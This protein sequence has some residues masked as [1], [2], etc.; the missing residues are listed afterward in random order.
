MP[1]S[2][3]SSDA[4]TTDSRVAGLRGITTLGD[5]CIH[6]ALQ[7]N[8]NSMSNYHVVELAIMLC[9][10]QDFMDNIPYGE[11][12]LQVKSLHSGPSY[13]T[14]GED[15]AVGWGSNQKGW[16]LYRQNWFHSH[17]PHKY[18]PLHGRQNV[19]SQNFLHRLTATVWERGPKTEYRNGF[20]ECVLTH[21]TENRNVRCSIWVYVNITTQC[22]LLK[23]V[24]SC[25][26]SWPFP[27][28]TTRIMTSSL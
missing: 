8:V 16:I 27:T 12:Y 24:H 5:H 17:L 1:R 21:N 4:Y 23:A 7:E 10:N 22:W 25:F 28:H 15:F 20:V 11:I 18:I 13:F 9:S 19:Y 6:S 14:V 3:P 2:A 26:Y